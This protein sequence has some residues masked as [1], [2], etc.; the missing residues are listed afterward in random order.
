MIRRTV[1]SPT[2]L[3]GVGVCRVNDFIVRYHQRASPTFFLQNRFRVRL[4]STSIARS[5]LAK[6]VIKETKN[7][8][9]RISR[10]SL[11]R[12]IELS[13]NEWTLVAMSAATLGVTSSITLLLPYASGQVIDYTI[14]AP[15][16]ALSPV[17]MAGGLFALS[18]IAGAGVYLRSLWLARAGNRI[19]ARLKQQLFTSIVQQESAFFDKQTT[20]D[21]ISRLSADTQLVEYVVTYHAVT[22]L[23]GLVMSVGSASMLLY[24][25]PTLAAISC[26]TLPP[27]FIATRHIGKQLEKEQER[28]QE[29][30]GE[31]T[32]LAEQTLSNIATIKQFTGEEYEARRYRNA[33]AAAHCKALE[34]A[35]M[36]AQLEAGAHVA[37]NAAVLCVLGYGGSM[38]LAGQITAGDLTGFVMYSLLLA[39][40]VSSLTA[41]YGEL[42]QAIAA[43]N[44]VFDVLDRKPAMPSQYVAG[45]M[46]NLNQQNSPLTFVDGAPTA[47]V[48]DNSGYEPVRIEFD[49]VSFNYPTREDVDVLK[50]FSLTVNPGEVVALV[51]GSGSGK[52]TV[53]SL[54]TR[55]YDLGDNGSI[56]INGK[57]IEEYDLRDLRHMI[58]V[59]SQEPVLFRGSMKDNIC[60]GEWGQ[61]SEEEITKAASLAHVLDFAMDFPDGLDTPVGPRGSQLSG[62]QR[63]RVALA[64]VLLK[65]PPVVILDEATSA[66]DAKSEHNVQLAMNSLMSGKRTVLSIAH[67]LSTIRHANR[68]AVVDQGSVVQ[69]GTYAELSTVDGPFRELMKPN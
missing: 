69:I 50:D 5:T 46:E 28:V 32:A 67:R 22:A 42:T 10:Q 52:S 12:L 21:L 41:L 27:I 11:L 57:R 26:C 61:A 3:R 18:A 24:T 16:D 25:S 63:Q 37:S 29:L 2:R 58:G 64:R 48:A 40:N 47:K 55:L 59:V 44:R 13:R 17:A 45:V 7:E 6:K 60:Y 15:E 51:G 1:N 20:G 9:T 56:R 43:S 33:V 19:V 68:I 65:N 62:G 23:R 36:Q 4:L 53:A 30:E 14:S 38:V 8:E 54:L 34:T 39:G 35:H 31:A 49:K 66:L